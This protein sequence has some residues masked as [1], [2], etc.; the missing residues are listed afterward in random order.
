[1][2]VPC[3]AAQAINPKIKKYNFDSINN[4]LGSEFPVD[5]PVTDSQMS[6]LSL[7]CSLSDHCEELHELNAKLIETIL[8]HSPD[9]NIKDMYSRTPLHHAAASSNLTAMN[10]LIEHC[11]VNPKPMLNGQV[12]DLNHQSVGGETALMKCVDFGNL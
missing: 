6:A 10:L 11:I 7:A 1:M 4:I 3:R 9:V 12:L 8:S 2:G 5:Y